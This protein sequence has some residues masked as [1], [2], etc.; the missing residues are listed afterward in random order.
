MIVNAI[1]FTAYTVISFIVGLFPLSTGFPQAAHTA[2]TT[3]G[4]YMGVW[5]PILPLATL[6][7]VVTLVLSVEVG[8]FGFKTIK[9][10]V[11]HIPWIG[12]K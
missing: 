5:S 10:V 3:L 12:G 8:I 11:S 6:L 7:T 4:G 2:M 1:I 9:W